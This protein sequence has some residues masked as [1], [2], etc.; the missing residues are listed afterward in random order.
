MAVMASF[1]LSE[2]EFR[3]L[4]LALCPS[5]QGA[6]ITTAAIKFIESLRSRGVDA[7]V[8]EG[9][10]QCEGTD[11]LSIPISTPD[12]GLVICPFKAHKG[13]MLMECPPSYLRYMAR[14]ITA[15]PGRAVQF[16]DFAHAVEEF[17]KQG[18]S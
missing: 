16:A 3:L 13:K 7:N 5:A 17:F 2:L 15:D 14:W 1:A 18:G 4:R 11:A 6:E 12:W 9:A 10:L 8:I